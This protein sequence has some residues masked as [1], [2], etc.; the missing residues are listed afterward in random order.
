MGSKLYTVRDRLAQDYEGTLEKV[1]AIGYKEIEPASGYN[2]L[3]P[4]QDAACST[5]SDSR[6]RARIPPR[7]AAA[8]S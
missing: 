4:K 1:A 8:S 5:G 7:A 3:A 6:C 2:N